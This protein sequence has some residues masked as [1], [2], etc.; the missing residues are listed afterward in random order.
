MH[1]CVPTLSNA[2]GGALTAIKVESDSGMPDSAGDPILKRKKEK[3]KE[4][5]LLVRQVI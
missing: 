4:L 1:W 2:D 3:G 5:G